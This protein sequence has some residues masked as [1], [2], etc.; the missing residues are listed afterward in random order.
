MKKFILRYLPVVFWMLL[1]FL[2]SS[3]SDLPVN[4]TITEDFLSKKLAHVFEYTVLMFFM[5]RAVGEKSPAKAF[6]YSLIFAFTDEIHQLFIPTRT[7]KLH[8]VGI[9]SLGLV[10]ASISIIKFQTWN[11]FLLV[12]PLRKLKK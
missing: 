7:G 8:D 12:H 1:I 6:L 10:L 3:K 11:S 2:M 5:F 9:D 4:G